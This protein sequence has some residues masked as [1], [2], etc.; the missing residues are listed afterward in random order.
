VT[1][2]GGLLDHMGGEGDTVARGAGE[3]PA[4]GGADPGASPGAGLMWSERHRPT[5]IESMVGNEKARADLVA[6][7]AGWKRGVRPALLVGPPGTG[8]TTMAT[9]VARRFG[10]DMVGINASDTRSRSRITALLGPVMGNASIVAG[11]SGGPA[12]MLVF[13]DEVDGIHGRADYGGADAL[14]RILKEPTVPIIMAANSDS[15]DKMKNIAKAS[16]VMRLGPVPPRL[17]RLYLRDAAAKEGAQIGPGSEIQVISRSRGDIRSMFNLAQS[18]AQGFSPDMSHEGGTLTAEEGVTAF[19]AAKT[20]HDA[21]MALES[22]RG[23]PREK[24][25]ALY[26]SVVSAGLPAARAARLMR[27]IS[28][29]DVI[30]GRIMRTQQWRL[31]RYLNSVL[32]A[33]HEAG[34]AVKHSKYGV[35]WPL[36]NRIRWDGSAIRALARS[37]APSFHASASEF[38]SV[39]LPYIAACVRAGA[40]DIAEF[41]EDHRAIVKKEAGIA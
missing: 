19:F 32:A 5:S 14:A 8:K 3:A 29:A 21:R 30:H 13:V 33:G 17:L 31:L 11:E 34:L 7:L 18:L 25:G 6:W 23:D 24:I 9:L 27:A 4:R 22:M 16:T 10:Y 12:R 28:E 20:A 36:L 38:I 37:E 35:S 2:R 1:R 39:H 26:S 15:S 41:D 40:V